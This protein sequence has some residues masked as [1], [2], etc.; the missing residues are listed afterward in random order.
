MKKNKNA[1]ELLNERAIKLARKITLA[2]LE[3]DTNRSG[4]FRDYVQF[5]LGSDA[6]AFDTSIVKEVLE[7]EEIVAV[8][9]TPDFIKGVV[10]VR[11]HICPVI[12]LCSFL[13]LPGRDNRV[14]EA[15]GNKVLFLSSSEMGFGVLIDEITDVFSVLDEDI[16]P[17]SVSNAASDRFSVGIINERI[18]VLDGSKI[19]VDPALIVNE[20][21]GGSIR[22][23]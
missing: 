8:P 17:L 11:G 21:V 1:L 16:K 12:D 3:T 15:S 14:D 20:V 19:L 6:Y 22:N 2:E 7:P 9:C 23:T 4:S 5:N 18:V 10:S 13:G